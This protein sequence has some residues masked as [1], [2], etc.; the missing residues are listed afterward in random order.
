MATKVIGGYEQVL[1]ALI[2]MNIES[3]QSSG[4]YNLEERFP[5]SRFIKG[6]SFLEKVPEKG[7]N[8]EK[9][10]LTHTYAADTIPFLQ[11]FISNI[12]KEC[13]IKIEANLGSKSADVQKYQTYEDFY[14]SVS[15]DSIELRL[16]DEI[17]MSQIVLPPEVQSLTIDDNFVNKYIHETIDQIFRVSTHA[18]KCTFIRDISNMVFNFLKV[19]SK[20]LALGVLY[21]YNVSAAKITVQ[22]VLAAMSLALSNNVNM[23][24]Y[25]A[26]K[27][28]YRITVRPI[29]KKT[30]KK[31]DEEVEEDDEEEVKETKTK[32]STGRTITRKTPSAK[33][34]TRKLTARAKA[35]Q[36]E[37]VEV[38]ED[39]DA[40]VDAKPVA[41]RV[42]SARSRTQQDKVA[43][44]QDDEDDY[45]GE[46]Q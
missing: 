14:Q 33:T 27:D 8:R 11:D 4:D 9:K 13:K 17:S 23:I 32:K 21:N 24:A 6:R 2:M 30:S 34:G 19:I 41:R 36:E 44:E 7:G 15:E 3:A 10:S 20:P 29:P 46:E 43:Q 22:H 26:T 37:D 39:N 18:K 31:K 45:G 28:N 5:E 38:E 42:P 12:I 35:T 40:E 1:T 25:L 16:I